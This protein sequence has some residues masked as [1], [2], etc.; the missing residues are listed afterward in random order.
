MILTVTMNPSI[1]MAYD[2]SQLKLDEVNRA[3]SVQKTAGGKGLNVTRVIQQM[4]QP[5]IATGLLGGRFGEFISDKLAAE[6]IA[7]DFTKIAGETRNSIAL[8][9]DGGK[10]TE[11]LE[12]G[13][14]ISSDERARFLKDFERLLAKAE[15]VTISGSL[16]QGLAAD[17]YSQ[18]IEIAKQKKVA[19]LLD[20][21]GNSLKTA[22][23][24][25]CPPLLIK[26]NAAELGDLINQKITDSDTTAVVAALKN[27]IFDKLEWISTSLGSNGAIVK[28]QNKLYR[29]EIPKVNAVSPVG[30]GDASLAGLAIGISLQQTPVDTI[31]TSMTLGILNALEIAT[32]WVNPKNFKKYFAQVKVTEI[33]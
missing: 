20:T 14:E 24:S 13:P 33:Q 3:V 6:K 9:H 25:K 15:L 27:P 30:S 7:A 11:V 19:V 23:A 26:P 5:V 10:Q 29:A 32:G 21:S 8:L 22:L 16:P 2:L 17:F 18:L 28:Y 1:D 4:G 31:K 12:K